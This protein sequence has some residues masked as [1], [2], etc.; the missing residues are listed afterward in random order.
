MTPNPTN[1]VPLHHPFLY[2]QVSNAVHS[3][4]EPEFLPMT[5]TKLGRGD[6]MKW[7]KLQGKLQAHCGSFPSAFRRAEVGVDATR[8]TPLT[9]TYPPPLNPSCQHILLIFALVYLLSIIVS[10]I[11]VVMGIVVVMVVVVVVVVIV[12][13]VYDDKHIWWERYP[14]QEIRHVGLS[15]TDCH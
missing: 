9:H 14:H 4:V 6:S 15:L 12:V 10:C 11:V 7:G 3:H 5:E 8:W 1:P 2:I 13:V